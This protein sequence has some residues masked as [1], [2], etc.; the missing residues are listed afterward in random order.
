M[1][2]ILLAIAVLGVMALIV[3]LLFKPYDYGAQTAVATKDEAL[4]VGAEEDDDETR[5][6]SVR[7]R[8]GLIACRQATDIRDHLFLSREAPELPLPH[9]SETDC[10]CHYIFHDDRRSGLDRRAQMDRVERL[11]NGRR[12]DRRRSPGRRAG[13]LAPA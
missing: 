2:W 1:M 7:V 3:L 13:D 6:R 5:W 9:C 11:L 10:R 4:A 12:E 8:P